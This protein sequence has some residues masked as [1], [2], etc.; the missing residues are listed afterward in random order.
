MLIYD[1]YKIENI[2]IID[3][4]PLARE[5]MSDIISDADFK[6]YIVDKKLNSVD[7]LFIVLTK[8][9]QAAI[10]DH[11]LSIANYANFNGAEAVSSLY[12]KKIPALLVTAYS[13]SDIDSI[14]LYRRQI[15]LIY[16]SRDFISENIENG[17]RVC[18]EEFKENY[19]ADRK[20]W[21]TLFRIEDLDTQR[22][23]A[24]IIIPSWD[25]KQ[26]IRLPFEIFGNLKDYINIGERFYA[27]VNIGAEKQED[28]FFTDIELPKKP[29]GKYADFIHS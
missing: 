29:K 18:I 13:K 16:N 20:S 10:F 1:G 2:A 6:P 12:I 22:E 26:T 15:P 28:L 19:S 8:T 5:S 27:Q 21:K 14:R 11:H 3:D 23:F 24:F 25:S 9:S 4:K 17:I 7:E